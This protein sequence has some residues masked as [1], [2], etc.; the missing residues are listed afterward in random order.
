MATMAEAPAGRLPRQNGLS[1]TGI[2]LSKKR[3]AVLGM[4]YHSFLTKWLFENTT[5]RLIFISAA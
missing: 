4:W 5:L 3:P 1:Q 2:Y